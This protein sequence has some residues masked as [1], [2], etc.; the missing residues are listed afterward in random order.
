MRNDL[1]LPPSAPSRLS[2][3]GWG[4]IGA[5]VASAILLPRLSPHAAL[6]YWLFMSIGLLVGIPGGFAYQADVDLYLLRNPAARR[7]ALPWPSD[8]QSLT[9]GQAR[10]Y[11][12]RGVP[13]ALAYGAL[14]PI[15]LLLAGLV[16]VRLLPAVVLESL[17]R[18]DEE[19]L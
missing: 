3:W 14:L 2:M 10:R 16:T 7:D 15:L 17:Y 11:A 1:D 6:M 8:H 18:G 13:S 12:L 9:T 4:A 19:A 5:S